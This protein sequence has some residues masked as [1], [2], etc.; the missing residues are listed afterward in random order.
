MVCS[1]RLTK[2]AIGP[3]GYCTM[4]QPDYLLDSLQ[5]HSCNRNGWSH[6]REMHHCCQEISDK[7]NKQLIAVI[8]WFVLGWSHYVYHTGMWERF[9]TELYVRFSFMIHFHAQLTNVMPSIDIV[10]YHRGRHFFFIG[11]Y[12]SSRP[13]VG[14]V[15]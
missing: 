7:S 1:I 8:T 14:N 9:Y 10:L 13:S 5:Y 12:G 15:L 6:C 11:V 4:F 3:L 2:H